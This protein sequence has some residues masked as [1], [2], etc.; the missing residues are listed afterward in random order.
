MDK[1]RKQLQENYEDAMFALLMDDFA[2]SEGARLLEESKAM[3]EDPAMALPEGMEER[4]LKMIRKAFRKKRLRTA[5][6]VGRKYVPRLAVLLL[7]LNIAFGVTFFTVEAFR[8]EVLNMALRF[9][10]TYTN[11]QFTGETTSAPAEYTA[12]DL[13]KVL[14]EGYTMESYEKTPAEEAAS[15]INEDGKKIWWRI[16]PIK[17]NVN[18]DT[19]NADFTK[20]ILVNGY[21]GV[22]TE[23]DGLVNILWGDTAAQKVYNI[24]GEMAMDDLLEIV[25][26]LTD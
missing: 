26:K 3:N 19:E 21:D 9:Q 7:V 13:Q 14:P 25:E 4:G 20:E 6:K 5:A 24:T 16:H 1:I 11:I 22:M 17:V 2:L 15:F 23:K 12:E 10:D 18:L 8:V